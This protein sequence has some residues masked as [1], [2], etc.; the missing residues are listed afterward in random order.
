ASVDLE[1]GNAEARVA[2]EIGLRPDL[3]LIALARLQREVEPATV[4]AISQL[5][6]GGRLKASAR[7]R[8][9][10]ERWGQLVQ[11]ACRRRP[12]RVGDAAAVVGIDATERGG[13]P[14][15]WTKR[16]GR[17]DCANEVIIRIEAHPRIAYAVVCLETHSA[18][19]FPLNVHAA[20]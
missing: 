8:I 14:A 12:S 3:V 1:Q 20:N 6:E 9:N 16:T 18:V 2:A 15:R 5:D 11:H 13:Q 17:T 10:I 19:P 7:I 4:Q